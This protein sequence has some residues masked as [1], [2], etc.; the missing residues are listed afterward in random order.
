METGIWL[1]KVFGP[2]LAIIGLWMLLY[3]EN[4]VKI[5]TSIRNS[6]SGVYFSA[7]INMLV[8]LVIINMFNMWM[9]DMTFFVTLLGWVLF[10][11][12]LLGLFAPHLLHKV[13]MNNQNFMKVVGIIPFIWGLLLIWAGFYIG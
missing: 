9:W 12:G 10:I 13:F 3:G 5:M 6:P 4:F 1:A 7:V 2:Y 11:R 8:G